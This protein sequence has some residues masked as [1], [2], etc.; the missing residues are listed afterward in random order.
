MTKGEKL[1]RH[2]INPSEARM[3]AFLVIQ[4]LFFKVSIVSNVFSIHISPYLSG[5]FYTD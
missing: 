3:R 4:I 5:A 2:F 1:G